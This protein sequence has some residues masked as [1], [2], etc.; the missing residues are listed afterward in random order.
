MLSVFLIF[1]KKSLFFY[2]FF[3]IFTISKAQFNITF[4]LANQFIIHNYKTDNPIYDLTNHF[5]Y[6][7][8]LRVGIQGSNIAIF[9]TGLKYQFMGG[10]NQA[11]NKLGAYYILF[12][13]NFTFLWKI[14]HS[15][16]QWF[17]DSGFCYGAQT[18][19][20]HGNQEGIDYQF[21][22]NYWGLHLAPGIEYLINS[23]FSITF[24]GYYTLQMNDASK[25]SFIGK[26]HN[27][28]IQVGLRYLRINKT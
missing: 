6:S 25:N 18:R 14:T 22:K 9:S 3:I 24:Q 28:G 11:N 8:E 17:F 4:H 26:F 27:Y 16:F 15:H 13:F 5:V 10:N 19:S 12:P 1:N 20:I 7:P 2:F 21:N 23:K